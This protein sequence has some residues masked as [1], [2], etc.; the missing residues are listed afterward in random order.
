MHALCEQSVLFEVFGLKRGKV[1]VRTGVP[2]RDLPKAFGKWNTVFRR[3]RR[4]A[5]AG[6]FERLFNAING[7][8]DLE[9]AMID[10]TIVQPKFS[11]WRGIKFE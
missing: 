5:I 10:G 8:P 1:L 9:C 7:E 2:W 11:S 3:F 6:V 4:W